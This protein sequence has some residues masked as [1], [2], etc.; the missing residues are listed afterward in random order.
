[1]LRA[2]GADLVGMSTVP[3]TIAAVHSGLKV[4]ALSVVTDLAFP[5]SLEPLDHA[6]VVRAA[7]DAAP[8]VG[9][10]LEGVLRRPK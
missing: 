5:D 7:E 3:E 6:G 4:L 2:L 1:M 8:R 10:I 9:K